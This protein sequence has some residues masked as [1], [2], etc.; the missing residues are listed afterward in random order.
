M[1]TFVTAYNK[2]YDIHLGNNII[3][4]DVVCIIV[5]IIK[6]ECV[7]RIRNFY[8]SKVAKLTD[9]LYHFLNNQTHIVD[10][11]NNDIIL[12][13]D[14]HMIKVLFDFEKSLSKIV[15]I[16]S[17]DWIRVIRA[18]YRSNNLCDTIWL[19]GEEYYHERSTKLFYNKVINRIISKIYP[20]NN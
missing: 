17:D 16:D 6:A 18:V 7:N 20:M 13:F 12:R 3:P 8:Y 10:E 9:V 15:K 1:E 5:D 19:N 4:T 14:N 11:I 2:N